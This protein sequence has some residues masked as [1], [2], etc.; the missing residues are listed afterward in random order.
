MSKYGNRQYICR[1]LYKFIRFDLN[2]HGEFCMEK[3]VKCFFLLF[4]F[5]VSFW[6]FS[7]IIHCIYLCNSINQKTRYFVFTLWNHTIF[8]KQTIEKKDHKTNSYA[9]NAFLNKSKIIQKSTF[10][11]TTIAKAK[12]KSKETVT[13]NKD[14]GIIPS[15]T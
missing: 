5:F 3:I 11:Q 14:T 9:A 4:C 10:E 6:F 2:R 12:T 7:A 1:Y 13:N 15:M 8:N